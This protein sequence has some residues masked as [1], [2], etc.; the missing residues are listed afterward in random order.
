MAVWC[1]LWSF[2]IFFPFWYVWT[3]KNLAT[4]VKLQNLKNLRFPRLGT[5]SKGGPSDICLFVIW[6]TCML[7]R[8]FTCLRMCVCLR[9][10]VFVYGFDP[11]SVVFT[12][13][14]SVTSTP[15][16]WPLD[17]SNLRRNDAGQTF[18]LWSLIRNKKQLFTLS[19]L[20]CDREVRGH[21]KCKEMP[22]IPVNRVVGTKRI[23]RKNGWPRWR[24]HKGSLTKKNLSVWTYTSGSTSYLSKKYVL[25]YSLDFANLSKTQSIISTYVYVCMTVGRYVCTRNNNTPLFT[26]VHPYLTFNKNLYFTV[27][28]LYRFQPDEQMFDIRFGIPPLLAWRSGDAEP[29]FA[30]I[31]DGLIVEKLEGGFLIK[32]KRRLLNQS[33]FLVRTLRKF[34]HRG[35]TSAGNLVCV[36]IFI[37]DLQR[38][39]FLSKAFNETRQWI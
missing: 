23:I 10:C 8:F 32:Q 3:K 14:A 27:F 1:S 6:C 22:V 20:S 11:V 17:A 2:G 16:R 9:A 37:F 4:L 7:V 28:A 34:R 33:K 12:L 30:K 5:E 15:D 35:I 29:Q 39:I 26:S 25:L 21:G 13:D 19:K 24:K 38:V 31:Y 36:F 18:G